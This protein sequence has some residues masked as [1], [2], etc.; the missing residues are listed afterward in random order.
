ME[1]RDMQN[2]PNP[3][4]SA[5][6]PGRTV[7]ATAPRCIAAARMQNEPNPAQTAARSG[8][9]EVMFVDVACD[10]RRDEVGERQAF[11]DAAADVGGADVDEGCLDDVRFEL[12][13]E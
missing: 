7:M 1:E 10:R 12:R 9:V 11:A 2:E 5:A 3:A 6:E 4:Q 8:A 13:A